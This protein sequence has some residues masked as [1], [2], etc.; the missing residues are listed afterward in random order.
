MR[1]VVYDR[2]GPPEVVS[3]REVPAPAC[4]ERQIRVRVRAAAVSSGD[5]RL[6]A[7]DL[8]PGF[9][10]IGRLFL[11]LRRPRFPVLGA[12]F[13]G[14]VEAVGAAVTRFAPGD[15]VFGYRPT[16][17]GCHAEQVVVDEHG[18]VAALPEGVSFEQGGAAC[19]GAITALVFLRDRARLQAG[20]SVLVVGASG[21]VGSAAVQIARLMGARVTGVCSGANAE[22][23]R[24]L[25]AEAVV[26]YTREDVL[27]R[28]VRY[29]VV[30]DA[31]GT[32][33]FATHRAILTDG[34]RLLLVIGS[35]WQMLAAPLQ[36]AL[37]RYRVCV[38]DTRGTPEDVR[39]LA[40]WMADGRYTPLIDRT[41]PFAEAA[42]AHRHVDT[43]HKR[44]N[45]VLV[46]S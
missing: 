17:L 42:E 38:G 25:G 3:V 11:G 39:L 33:R 2:F 43:G 40:E 7:A 36:S 44:G 19:F 37:S 6:R 4:G 35:L 28:G 29:D 12:D 18:Q 46:P 1:A 5:R 34:G 21:A 20:E 8:P 27:A 45:V 22:R 15:R 23:V 14:E 13:A 16:R 41:H 30:L 26:D 24:G 32:T 31:A 9:G 10:L